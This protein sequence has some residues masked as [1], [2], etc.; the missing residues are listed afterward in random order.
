MAR[1]YR[2][3]KCGTFHDRYKDSPLT[4]IQVY[5]YNR[6]ELEPFIDFNVY[7]CPKCDDY[8]IDYLENLAEVDGELPKS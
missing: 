1:A 8:I 5:R 7:L 6:D 3:D 4:Q 2:C